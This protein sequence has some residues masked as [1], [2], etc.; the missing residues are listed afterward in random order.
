MEH[1]MEFTRL[2]ASYKRDEG[3][4]SG[5]AEISFSLVFRGSELS[6][7]ACANVGCEVEIHQGPGRTIAITSGSP[8]YWGSLLALLSQ[9][10]R[11]LMVFDGCFVSIADMRFSGSEGSRLPTAG[12]CAGARSHALKSRLPYYRSADFM[13]YDAKLIDFRNVLSTGLF[14]KWQGVLDDLEIVNQVY[15]YSVS[16]NGMPRDVSL[17]FLVEMAEPMV[18]LLQAEQGVF[19]TLTP[20]TR[21]TSLKDCLRALISRYGSVIFK[22]EISSGLEDILGR[23]KGTRVQIM[24]IKRNWPEDKRLDG[25]H[26]VFYILK[27]SLLYRVVL[28]ELLGIEE[29][30]YAPRVS[31]ITDRLDRWAA[32]LDS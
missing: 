30:D 28:L 3:I 11:L 14:A 6:K 18:E 1:P 21:D 25:R 22:N 24:H 23:L 19:P 2:V 10:E 13:F 31:L 4:L 20:G 5:P 32:Q 26:C 16:D 9:V 29:E 15:L 12:D 8:L 7:E 27:L 17:A